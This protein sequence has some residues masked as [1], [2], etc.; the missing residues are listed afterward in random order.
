MPDVRDAFFTVEVDHE[1]HHLSME[2]S[3]MADAEFATVAPAAT[4]RVVGDGAD[5]AGFPG[6]QVARN[7]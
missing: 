7:R 4:R 2:L 6:G 5:L 1:T 3:G